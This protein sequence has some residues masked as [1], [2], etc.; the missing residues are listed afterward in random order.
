[1]LNLYA[2]TIWHSYAPRNFETIE[3][4]TSSAERAEELAAE[5][6]P[7]CDAHAKLVD[8]GVRPSPANDNAPMAATGTAG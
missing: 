2:V 3:V 5:S 7:Y 8:A 1:M 4:R 6:F